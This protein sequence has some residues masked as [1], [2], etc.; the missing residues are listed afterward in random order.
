MPIPLI[1]S[2]ALG[3][4]AMDAAARNSAHYNPFPAARD[5]KRRM[6]PASE[7]RGLERSDDL[8]R[9]LHFKSP[10]LNLGNYLLDRLT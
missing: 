6:A 4:G 7:Q 9:T 8:G 10:C 1:S 2:E 3:K 5:A